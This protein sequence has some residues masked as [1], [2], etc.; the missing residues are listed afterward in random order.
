MPEFVL[1]TE[2]ERQLYVEALLHCIDHGTLTEREVLEDLCDLI[3]GLEGQPSDA[4]TEF[5]RQVQ[6]ILAGY[7]ARAQDHETATERLTR[8]FNA[9]LETASKS[10]PK[11]FDRHS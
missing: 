2:T 1:K 6:R 7:K 3:P 5:I 9:P 4:C 8:L 10:A 11:E